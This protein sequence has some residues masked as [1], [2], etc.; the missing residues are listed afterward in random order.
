MTAAHHEDWYLEKYESNGY[1]LVFNLRST[2]KYYL[3]ETFF[4]PVNFSVF[5]YNYIKINSKI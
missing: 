5:I 1:G 2:F 3:N 4:R